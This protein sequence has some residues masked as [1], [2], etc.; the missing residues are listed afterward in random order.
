MT[1]KNPAVPNFLRGVEPA[2]RSKV[3]TG[4]G[5]WVSCQKRR[6][7]DASEHSPE[8]CEDSQKVRARMDS[9]DDRLREEA[10][11]RTRR[12]NVEKIQGLCL[13]SLSLSLSLSLMTCDFFLSC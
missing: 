4:V 9:G 12:W 13:L 6:G 8:K 10:Y 3:V 11:V 2:D 7:E 1:R 5:K